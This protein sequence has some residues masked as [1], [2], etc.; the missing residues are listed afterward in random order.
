[1]H[2]KQTSTKQK[3]DNAVFLKTKQQM[4]ITSMKPQFSGTNLNEPTQA[5]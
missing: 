1:M 3:M 2:Q 4:D 5:K